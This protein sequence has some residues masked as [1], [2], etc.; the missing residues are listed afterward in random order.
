MLGGFSDAGFV[1]LVIG[2]LADASAGDQARTVHLGGRA[3]NACI[4]AL[5]IG[6]VRPSLV[7]AGR[8][9]KWGGGRDAWWR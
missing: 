9:V 5:E 4:D 2:P 1:A 8:R 7:C 6:K 3:Y